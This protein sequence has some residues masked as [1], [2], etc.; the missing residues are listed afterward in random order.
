MTYSSHN[1]ERRESD[2]YPRYYSAIPQIRNQALPDLGSA[3][4]RMQLFREVQRQ[5]PDSWLY[6]SC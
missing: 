1:D 2:A 6:Y 4:G 5:R 3:D